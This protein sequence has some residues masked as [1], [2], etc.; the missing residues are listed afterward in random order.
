MLINLLIK[1]FL[2][3]YTTVIL[4]YGLLAGSFALGAHLSGALLIG[5]QHFAVECG[6]FGVAIGEL[7][8]L[9]N[10]GADWRLAYGVANGFFR[11]VTFAFWIVAFP[12]TVGMTLYSILI[13]N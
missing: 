6:A 1:I 10:V 9:A 4:T 2:L 12:V 5:A 7:K 3:Y 8:F 13:K 11:Y